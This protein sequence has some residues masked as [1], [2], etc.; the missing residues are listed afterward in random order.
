[1]IRKM[2]VLGVALMLS[3][4]SY[5]PTFSVELP[6]FFGVYV[7]QKEKYVEIVRVDKFDETKYNVQ[8]RPQMLGWK[9]L[10]IKMSIKRNLFI[11]VDVEIFNKEGFL[12]IQDPE[13]SDF[14]FFR[15]PHSGQWIDN[16]KGEDIITSISAIG[17]FPLGKENP[18]SY[19]GL[20]KPVEPIEIN[21]KKGKVGDNAYIYIPTTP[22]ENGIY[23][24]DYK[25]NGKGFLGYNPLEIR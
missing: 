15:V 11:P 25:K 21:L 14:K 16:E 6:K 3:F 5:E 1:M 23:L 12:V 17:I 19:E 9:D 18:F 13:W 10:N 24:I 2:S 8:P 7:L 22:L 20:D 4:V